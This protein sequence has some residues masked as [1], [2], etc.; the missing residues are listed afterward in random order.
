LKKSAEVVTTK[1]LP[2]PAN[3]RF[4]GEVR[5][6]RSQ[7][8]NIVMF[9]PYR[10]SVSRTSTFLSRLA[11]CAFQLV[12]SLKLSLRNLLRLQVT[13]KVA[14]SMP[15][16]RLSWTESHVRPGQPFAMN[17]NCQCLRGSP[18]LRECDLRRG[19]YWVGL[20]FHPCQR[21]FGLQSPLAKPPRR[22]SVC[23]PER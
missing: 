18:T 19:H 23:R 9:P 21:R 15:F 6:Q 11:S 1:I 7:L 13:S 16:R 14:V 10:R 4:A 8:R 12:L 3:A 17:M 20:E 2:K 22:T 5:C